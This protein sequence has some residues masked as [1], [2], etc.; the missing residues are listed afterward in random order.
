MNEHFSQ[1]EKAAKYTRSHVPVRLEAVWE[2]ESRT[3]AAQLEYRIKRL[4]K[5]Q[6]EQLIKENALAELLK[7]KLSCEA[8]KRT[9]IIYNPTAQ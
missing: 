7:N 3:T 1:S 8:Y 4:A 2:S 5:T 6:K 9:D